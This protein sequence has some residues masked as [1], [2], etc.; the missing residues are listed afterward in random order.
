MQRDPTLGLG[1]LDLPHAI[2]RM[3]GWVL[4][5]LVDLDDLALA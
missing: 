5:A 4:Y 3:D 1:F 2:E